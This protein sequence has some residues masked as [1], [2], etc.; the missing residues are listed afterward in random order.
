MERGPLVEPNQA[1]AENGA[2]LVAIYRR[3]GAAASIWNSGIIT[4]PVSG[5]VCAG[6]SPKQRW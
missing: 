5:S 4:N 1:G 3:N 2:R 6:S